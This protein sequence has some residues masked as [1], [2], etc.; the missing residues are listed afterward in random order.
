MREDTAFQEASDL[1]RISSANAASEVDDELALA[2]QAIRNNRVADAEAIVRGWFDRGR[3]DAARLRVAA[4]L[5]YRKGRGRAAISL[6]Q[7]ALSDRPDYVEARRDLAKLFADAKRY[8]EAA[9]QLGELSTAGLASPADEQTKADLLWRAGDFA[10][11][12]DASDRLLDADGGS[13]SLWVR[14]GDILRT[15]GRKEESIEAYRTALAVAPTCGEAWWGLANLKTGALSPADLSELR[16]AANEPRLAKRDAVPLHFALGAALEDVR[17]YQAAFAAYSKANRL[18]RQRVEYHAAALSAYVDSSIKLF[19]EAFFAG[20]AGQGSAA[21]DPIFILGMPRSGSTL[22]EQILASHPHVEGTM[23]LSIMPQLAQELHRQAN[24]RGQGEYP[25]CLPRLS[26]KDLERAGDIYIERTRPFRKTGRPLFIDKLPMNWMHAPLIRSALPNARIID[27]RRH[28]LDCCFSN[29]RQYFAKGYSFTY[30]L[31]ELGQYYRDYSRLMDH[32][33]QASPS[34]VHRVIHER[35]VAE[36]E[37]EVR[38]LLAF[39][40]LDFDENCLSFYKN[41]RAVRTPSSEQVRRPI[42]RDGFDRWRPF[43]PWLQ[44][45]RDAL[46]DVID[47]YPYAAA[48]TASD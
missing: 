44:P 19:D 28:P 13:A 33:A 8:G 38:R 7:E 12:L 30:D 2:E 46:G 34:G 31:S 47:T 3:P 41:D 17:D 15:L 37:P 25:L 48:G 39:C 29:Y 35:L 24:A 42:N 11:A 23:E 21:G 9:R 40:G 14:R 45:L 27:A 10:A 4:A 32:V 5:E 43:E 16:K 22:L 26:A 18:Q 20:R 36:P 6:L 1:S